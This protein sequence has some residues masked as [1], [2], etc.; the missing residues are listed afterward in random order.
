MSDFAFSYMAVWCVRF[1]ADELDEIREGRGR[2]RNTNRDFN[3][4]RARAQSQP[5]RMNRPSNN[6]G[7][8]DGSRGYSSQN[9]PHH[10]N[11]GYDTGRH[12]SGGGNNTNRR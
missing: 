7:P 10:V 1:R 11:R 2:S 5:P 12:D 6:I 9:D 3:G 8:R 4:D